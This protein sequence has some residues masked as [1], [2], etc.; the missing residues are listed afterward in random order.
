MK[1]GDWVV[2]K[3]TAASW[4]AGQTAQIIEEIRDALIFTLR[5]RD[6]AEVRY[7]RREVHPA[8]NTERKP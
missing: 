5:F 3:E 6:G 8:H 7:L 2:V 1:P 4:R